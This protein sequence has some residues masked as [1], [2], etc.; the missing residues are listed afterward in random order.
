MSAALSYSVELD[1]ARAVAALEQFNAKAD[2]MA[3]KIDGIRTSS[4]GAEGSTSSFFDKV[5]HAGSNIANTVAGLESLGK[6][7]SW[8]KGPAKAAELAMDASTAA[9]RVFEA[10]SKAAGT[11][12]RMA[13]AGIGFLGV[14]AGGAVVGVAALSLAL[15]SI[16]PILLA[17]SAGVAA[18]KSISS[19][20]GLANE[21]ERTAIAFKTLTGSAEQAAEVVGMLSTM[22]IDT[23]FQEAELQ[24]GA[25]SL[26]AARV[27]ASALKGELLAIGNVAAATGGDIGRLSTVYAQVAGKG[28]LYAEE[29]QQFVEQ[30]AGELRQA[31]AST[32]GVTTGE[33][34]DMMSHGEVAFSTLQQAMQ[35]LAGAGGKWGNA[36]A[37]QSATNIGLLSSLGDNVSKIVRLL[38]TPITMG[39]IKAFLEGAVKVSTM[40]STILAQGMKD[41]KMG[42]ILEQGLI[43]GAKLGTIEVLSLIFKMADLVATPIES[44]GTMMKAALTGN[45]S[46]IAAT[47]GRL[48]AMAASM[49]DSWGDALD[50]KAQYAFF[51][52][53][54]AGAKASK[55][56]AEETGKKWQNELDAISTG[57]DGSGKGGGKE[58]PDAAYHAAVEQEA[59]N[60]DLRAALRGEDSAKEKAGADGLFGNSKYQVKKPAS[61]GG[62][63]GGGGGYRDNFSSFPAEVGNAAGK[64][65]QGYRQLQGGTD[66][67]RRRAAERM[68]AGDTKRQAATTKGF[69]TFAGE[70]ARLGDRFAK[71]FGSIGGS[72]VVPNLPAP[73]APAAVGKRV[74]DALTPPAAS[75]AGA[76][77]AGGQDASAKKL[78]EI[79]KELQRIRTE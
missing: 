64:K 11:G 5:A 20:F 3:A 17:V 13:G 67:A 60:M 32:L 31:V 62:G 49:K 46:L 28:K 63:G 6:V 52:S 72:P 24:Q 14:T 73:G 66:D 26:L 78:D 35:D 43:L 25:R 1:N 44:I 36:M 53:L 18:V 21:A 30:G 22:A 34:M 79:L 19:G 27:P 10:G 38:A 23:P 70:S 75:K 68:T 9:N 48:S 4:G 54:Q 45:I 33:L 65:I 40:V 55:K 74:Q 8:L 58:K 37:E 69:G 76:G 39:P 59:K 41:G 12:A 42:E 47:A 57:G 71:N 7:L 29:L 2:Q 15:A 77:T 51:A 16:A 50:P 56:D 61:S